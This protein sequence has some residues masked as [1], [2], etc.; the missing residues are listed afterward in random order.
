[1]VKWRH[2]LSIGLFVLSFSYCIL[3]PIVVTNETTGDTP[4]HLEC[5]KGDLEM[6]RCLNDKEGSLDG[7]YVVQESLVQIL[8]LFYKLFNY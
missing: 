2:G 1:M 8:N 5:A 6:I 4:F 3:G 7:E